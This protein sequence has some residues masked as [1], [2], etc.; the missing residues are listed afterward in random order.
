MTGGD[1]EL[2]KRMNFNH[3]KINY[4]PTICVIHAANHNFKDQIERAKNWG[5]SL[6][7]I[8]KIY[9]WKG[10]NPRFRYPFLVISIFYLA[11]FPYYLFKHRSLRGSIAFISMLLVQGLYF[12]RSLVKHG[13]RA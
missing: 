11:S 7:Y 13:A 3:I 10:I 9:G 12:K 4:D 5:T 1:R 6:A 8:H 2:G